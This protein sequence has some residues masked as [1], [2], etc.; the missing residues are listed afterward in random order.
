MAA[1]KKAVSVLRGSFF[2]S[3]NLNASVNTGYYETNRDQQ[4]QTISFAD[5]FENNMSQYVGASISIPIFSKNQ[6]RSEVRKSEIAERQAQNQL[7][8]YRQL[9]YYELANNARELKALFS[10]YFQTQKQLEANELSYKIAERKYDQGLIDVIELLTV[11]NRLA[12]VKSNLLSTRL[13]WEVK[14]K[15]I[16]FYKGIRFWE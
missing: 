7:E 15:T 4:G 8:N 1:A 10:E 9:V 2:P 6:I 3:L 16:D 13:R 5:Q 12:E 14:N 11:K